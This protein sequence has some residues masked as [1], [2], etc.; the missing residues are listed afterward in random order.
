MHQELYV[1]RV[2]HRETHLGCVWGGGWVISGK[3]LICNPF[4]S[5]VWKLRPREVM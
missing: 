1:V 4:I 3:W 5:Q 2:F